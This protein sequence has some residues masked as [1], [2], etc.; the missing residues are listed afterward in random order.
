MNW[1]AARI[2]SLGTQETVWNAER[3]ALDLTA[4]YA[5]KRGM[6]LFLSGRN[7]NRAPWAYYSNEPGRGTQLN[8]FGSQWNLGIKGAL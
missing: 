7:I 2:T 8:R 4:S 1:T 5:L 3:A 6:D